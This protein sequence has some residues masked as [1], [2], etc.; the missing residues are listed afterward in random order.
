MCASHHASDTANGPGA[1]ITDKLPPIVTLDERRLLPRHRRGD[2]RAFAELVECYRAPV[3]G[4]LVRCGVPQGVR[5]DLFQEVFVKVHGAAAAYQPDRPLRPWLFAIVAN[6]VRTHFRRQRVDQLVL[7]EDA[8][9][10]PG[11]EAG[12]D[13]QAEAKQT[14]RWLDEEIRKLPLAQREVLVLRCV[15]GIE[16]AQVAKVFDI[17]VGTVKTHLHKARLALTRAMARR[18]ARIAREVSS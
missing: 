4:Y 9:M 11:G 7:G 15:E 13:R 10:R 17:P 1:E 12:G 3:Y 8:E 18:N 5:D 6:T 2:P 14:A 16:E